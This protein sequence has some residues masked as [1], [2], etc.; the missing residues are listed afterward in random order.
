MLN[1]LTLSCM[2]EN[3]CQNVDIDFIASNSSIT[4]EGAN[5]CR[6]LSDERNQFDLKGTNLEFIDVRM[7][8]ICSGAQSC[9]YSDF[10]FTLGDNNNAYVNVDCTGDG[11]CKYST[12]DALTNNYDS[13]PSKEQ[14]MNIACDGLNDVCEE[15]TV[16]A[17]PSWPGH[18]NKKLSF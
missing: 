6:G 1:K 12:F 9:F 7:D 14:L 13:F 2:E 4:C 17:I 15:S 8:I 16:D 11:S 10:I 5:S 18:N 3:S